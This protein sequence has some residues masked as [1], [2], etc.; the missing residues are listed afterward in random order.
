MTPVYIDGCYG[1]LHEAEGRHG[2]VVCGSLGEEALNSY[3]S[4]VFLGEQLAQA[5]FPTLRISYYGTGDSAGEDDEPGRFRAW[6]D[7]IVAAARWLRTTCGVTSVSLCGI[8]IG[9]ALAARAALDIDDVD[10]LVLLAPTTS[11]R[12]FLR[13]QIL[14]ARTVAEIWQSTS[15][16]DDGQWFEAHGLRIDRATRDALDALDIGKLGRL[17]VRRVLLLDQA[18]A[19]GLDRLAT[20]LRDAGSNVT[21]HACEGCGDMLRESHEIEVPHAA[22]ADAVAWLG[23]A[24]HSAQPARNIPA[25]ALELGSARETP[26]QL[27]PADALAGI[28]TTPRHCRPD[29]PVVLMPSTGANPRVGNSRGM[30][31]L[32][33]WLAEQGIASLRMDGHGVGDAAPITGE[34]GM[35]YSKQGDRDVSAGVDFLAARFAG[36]IVVLGM[37]SGAYH[38]FQAALDDKR[39]NG[40]MLVNMQKFVWHGHE[41]LSV[42]QRTTFRTTGYYLRN[43]TNIDV[44]R[45]LLQGKVNVAGIAGALANRAARHIAAA[46]DPAIAALAGETAVGMVRRQLIELSERSVQMLY[47]LSGNDPGLDEISEYFGLRGW[48]LRRARHLTF[49]TLRGADH[50]LSAHWARQRLRQSIAIYL[51]QR[52]NVAVQ[53]DPVDVEQSRPAVHRPAVA[54]VVVTQSKAKVPGRVIDSAPTAA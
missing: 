37:C 34:H 26:V 14:S 52:F 40:L 17:P 15:T 41:S 21:Y 2:V 25:P 54:S 30:V 20:K 10:A 45:R 51:R 47:V 23:D 33:R 16:I 29:S 24:G 28:L 53:I 44:W 12:R 4:Q 38:A 11:G 1:V 3:R 13:E 42:V 19:A 22:F 27:G 36:P 49:R 31:A 46:A 6:L 8:R 9:A 43:V 39:I 5:G 7:S 18:D 48:R 32:A 35:P 50:T